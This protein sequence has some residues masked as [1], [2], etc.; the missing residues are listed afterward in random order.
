MG[1]PKEEAAERERVND[2][3]LLPGFLLTRLLSAQ[4]DRRS[5]KY[6]EHLEMRVTQ[7]YRNSRE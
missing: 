4:K 1:F 3:L 7:S 6:R 2:G 5:R